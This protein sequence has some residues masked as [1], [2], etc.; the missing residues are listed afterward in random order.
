MQ[1]ESINHKKMDDSSMKNP[2]VK[3]TSYIYGIS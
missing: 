3:S 1:Q 2:E